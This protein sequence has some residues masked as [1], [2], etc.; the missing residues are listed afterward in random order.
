MSKIRQLI[1][2]EDAQGLVEYIL[3]IAVIAVVAV[4]VVKGFGGKIVQ[5][6]QQSE[7]KLNDSMNLD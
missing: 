7:Q 6:F 4:A 3:I 5:W 1:M 2:E